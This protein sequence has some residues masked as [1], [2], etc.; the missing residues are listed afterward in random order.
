MTM[1]NLPKE[2]DSKFD[3]WFSG[4]EY[5]VAASLTHSQRSDVL[6]FSSQAHDELTLWQNVGRDY[7][8]GVWTILGARMGTYMT[9][10]TPTW[11]YTSVNDEHAMSA[12]FATIAD[13]DPELVAARVGEDLVV[14]LNLPIVMLNPNESAFLRHYL[15]LT[16]S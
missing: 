7:A 8:Y 14:E 5:A 15:E 11:D 4:F 16:Q 12:L 2:Y 9:L 3:A 13:S 6:E 10:I 1:L